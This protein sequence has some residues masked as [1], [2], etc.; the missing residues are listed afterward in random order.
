MLPRD[1][2]LTRAAAPKRSSASGGGSETFEELRLD[3]QELVDAGDHVATRL[4][5]YGRG[6]GSGMEIEEELYHQVTSFEAGR[7]VRIRYFTDWS[8]ALA[9]ARSE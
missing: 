7:I 9:A 4:C 2:A 5:Y 3:P 8:E 1:R 6:K